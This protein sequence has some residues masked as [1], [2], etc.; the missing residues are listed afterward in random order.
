MQSVNEV[1]NKQLKINKAYIVSCVNSRVS[2]L[3]QA[4][5]VLKGQKVAPGVELYI[6]AASS[7]VQAESEASG[8]WKALVDAGAK[9]LPPGIVYIVFIAK[10][11]DVD[12]VLALEL[13]F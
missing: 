2:D 4:A 3:S 9:T 11:K 7:E 12:L 6:S 5:K 1:E 8:D 10:M 13:D